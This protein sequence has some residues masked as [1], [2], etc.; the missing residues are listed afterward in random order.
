MSLA[1][2][3]HPSGSAPGCEMVYLL[4]L[5][6]T[7][8]HLARFGLPA[9]SHTLPASELRGGGVAEADTSDETSAAGDGA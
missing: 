3:G 8:R 7:G 9:L 1:T 6:G 5:T 4:R 2:L